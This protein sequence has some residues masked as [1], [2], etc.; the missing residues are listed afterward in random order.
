MMD[1]YLD[2]HKY[3][4]YAQNKGSYDSDQGRIR[5]D[6][7]SYWELPNIDRTMDNS[8]NK[9]PANITLRRLVGEKIKWLNLRTPAFNLE[10]SFMPDCSE[11]Q[12]LVTSGGN[13]MTCYDRAGR[14]EKFFVPNSVLLPRDTVLLVQKAEKYDENMKP[15]GQIIYILDAAILNGDDVSELPFRTRLNAAKKFCSVVNKVDFNLVDSAANDRSKRDRVPTTTPANDRN[16]EKRDKKEFK[17]STVARSELIVAEPMRL[18][19]LLEKSIQTKSYKGAQAAVV[20]LLGERSYKILCR[21]VRF[22]NILRPNWRIFGAKLA[23]KSIYSTIQETS[24]RR[25][26]MHDQ[27]VHPPS[28]TVL[29]V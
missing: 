23:K 9:C 14:G 16:R 26:V 15:V 20:D 25:C 5:E 29:I 1:K 28:M 17:T 7:L 12:I 21:G 19:N 8:S 10:L 11:P 18:K 3:R 2:N 24:P 6:C 4:L 22:V 27:T 13:D